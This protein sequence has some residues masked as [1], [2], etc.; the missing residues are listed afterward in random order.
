MSASRQLDDERLLTT[1]GEIAVINL[2]SARRRSWSSFFQDPLREGSAETVVELE[3]QAAEFFGDFS[4]FDRLEY[5]I[6][7]LLEADAGSARTMLIHAQLASMTHRFADARRYLARPDLTDAQTA[8]VKSLL[9][10]VDQACGVNPS[11]VLAYRREAAKNPGRIQDL[12]ALGAALVDLSEFAEAERIYRHALHVYRD[13]SPFPVAWICFQ[14]GV[15]WG[16]LVPEPQASKAEEWYQR[17]ISCV[18]RYA[19]ARVHLAEIYSLGG[20]PIEAQDVLIPVA[21]SSDPEVLWRLADA[22]IAQDKYAEAEVKMETARAGFE[23]LL[24]RHPLA[25]ADHA[26]GFFSANGNWRRALDLARMNAANRPTLRALELAHGIAVNASDPAAASEL[27][28]EAELRWGSTPAF[29]L[30]RF[31]HA[32]SEKRQGDAK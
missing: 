30:S 10:N 16:E 14:L 3:K 17:A 26:A 29:R 9:L 2:E 8:E 6:S 27:L 11:K 28:T 1:D 19:K 22:L 23:S 18:P 12:V 32:T 7:C 31:A 20:R 21:A 24:E 4:A 5:L 15:L 25:F 13:V